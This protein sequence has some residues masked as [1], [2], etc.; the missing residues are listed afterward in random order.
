MY[1]NNTCAPSTS[2]GVNDTYDI[3]CRV[4]C[5][6]FVDNLMEESDLYNSLDFVIYSTLDNFM[7]DNSVEANLSDS[8]YESE[9]DNSMGPTNDGSNNGASIP[10]TTDSQ[11][12]FGVDP[13]INFCEIPFSLHRSAGH[14]SVYLSFNING[15]KVDA[16]I[17]TGLQATVISGKLED[18]LELKSE[19]PVFVRGATSHTPVKA[20]TCSNIALEIDNVIYNWH[21][22]IVLFLLHYEIDILFSDGII[23]LGNSYAN[24]QLE[25]ACDSTFELNIIIVDETIKVKPWCAKLLRYP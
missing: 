25:L 20:R 17:D 16:L 19:D 10:D 3:D 12:E 14:N 1:E 22:L 9:L 8:A 11:T 7:N 15:F 6:P 24:P 5:F 13:S 21:V 2:I 23:S 18:I 4:D